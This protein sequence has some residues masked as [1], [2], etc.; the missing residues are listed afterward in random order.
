MTTGVFQSCAKYHIILCY[1]LCR[2]WYSNLRIFGETWAG[3]PLEEGLVA[4]FLTSHPPPCT[5]RCVFY[6]PE[7]HLLPH[8]FASFNFQHGFCF[9][10]CALDLQCTLCASLVEP[11]IYLVLPPT[12]RLHS[13]P[14]TFY[15][16]DPSCPL[17]SPHSVLPPAAYNAP[18]CFGAELQH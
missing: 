6:L 11:S 16:A 5:S 14:H 13:L 7:H 4:P 10:V 18:V 1:L 9:Y 15:H 8:P 3:S 17:P 2:S 12:R